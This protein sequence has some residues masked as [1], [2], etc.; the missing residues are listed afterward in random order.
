MEVYIGMDVHCKKTGYA[1]QE[2]SGKVIALEKE[3]DKVLEPFRETAGQ[4]HRGT[5][6]I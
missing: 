1:I 2:G 3:L 4:L 5:G 6:Q